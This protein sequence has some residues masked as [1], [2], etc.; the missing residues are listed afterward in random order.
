MKK[1]LI[2]LLVSC[3]CLAAGAQT[4]EGLIVTTVQGDLTL[5]ISDVKEIDFADAE[6]TVFKND[7]TAISFPNDAGWQISFGEIE[8]SSISSASVAAAGVPAKIFSADGKFVKEVSTISEIN[9]DNLPKGVYIIRSNGK[10]LK[11]RK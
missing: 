10:S 3:A 2:I 4:T 5:A 7:E 8:I 11:I 9:V 1:F 6:M